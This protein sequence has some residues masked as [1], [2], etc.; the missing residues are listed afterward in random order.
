MSTFSKSAQAIGPLTGGPAG[1]MAELGDRWGAR[2][3]ARAA[4]GRR[5]EASRGVCRIRRGSPTT[6]DDGMRRAPA[7]ACSREPA[8]VGARVVVS[9]DLRVGV[10]AVRHALGAELRQAR[11]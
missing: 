1:C 5:E 2:A 8:Q 3:A 11:P 9:Q 6:E 4:L 10:A 7:R